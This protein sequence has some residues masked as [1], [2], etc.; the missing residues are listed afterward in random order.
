MMVVTLMTCNNLTLE[1]NYILR[2]NLFAASAIAMDQENFAILATNY[3]P[4]NFI[5][6]G[7]ISHHVNE[8][9]T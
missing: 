1:V 9:T 6:S 8:N 4:S 7:N 3:I 2:V 5:D